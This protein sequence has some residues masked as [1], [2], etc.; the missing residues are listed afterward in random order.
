M[1]AKLGPFALA[2]ERMGTTADLT[3]PATGGNLGPAD[4]AF[5]FKPPSGIGLA[6]DAGVVKGGGYLFLDPDKGEYA[7]IL[8]LSFGPVSIKAIGI[9][10]TKLPGG[11]DG[12]ALLLLVFGE[13]SAVQLGFGFTLNGVGGIIGLQHGVSIEALQSGLRTGVLDSVLFPDDPVANAPTLI[14]QLRVVFPIVP[15]ALTVGPA[16]KLGWSTP[17]LVTLSLGIILQFDDVLGSGPGS[18]SF[19]RVVLLGQLKVQVPPVDELGIDA[20]ALIHLQVDILGAYDVP[21]QALSVDAVLRDSHVALLPITGS[22]VVRARFGDDPT[23][24]LAVGGFHPRFNDLPPGIPPQERVGLQLVY[25]IVTVRIVGYVAIT[26]N[27]FQTGA[28]ASLV[29]AGGGFRVEAY[30]GFDALFI[31]EPTFHFEIDFRVGA[32]V[33]YKS[34]S[35]ASLK[36]RGT[37][38]G[39]G[40]WEVDGHA[41][42]SLFFFDVDI[43]FEVAWGEA[44]APALPGVKVDREDRDGSV[45]PGV[46]ARRAARLRPAGDAAHRRRRQGR[47]GPPA[48]LTGRRTEGGAARHRH[49]PRRQVRAH[50]RPPLRHHRRHRRHRWRGDGRVPRRALRPGRVPRPHRGAEAVDPVLRAVPRRRLGRHR[51]LRHPRL[52]GRLRAAVGD[53]RPSPGAAD[54]DP[55]RACEVAGAPGRPRRRG[56]VGHPRRSPAH[57][58]EGPGLGGDR[59][60]HRRLR[61]RGRHGRCRLR[62]VHRG[63]PGVGEGPR[64]DVRR[65]PRRAGGEAVSY[66][67]LPHVRRGLADRIPDADGLGSTIPSRARFPV[68][69][70]LESG[71]TAGVD[72]RLYGPGDVIGV[73]PRGIVRTEP[74][75]F[76]RDVDPDGF[77]AIEFDAPDFPWMFTPARAGTNDQ[78]RPWLA[79]VVVRKQPGVSVGVGPD[80]PLPTLNIESPAVPG[81]EL[82][83]LAESWAWAHTHVVE[84]TAPASVPDHLEAHPELNLARLVCPRRLE[85]GVEYIAALVPAFESGRLAG[86]GQTVPDAATTTAAWG[87]S[88]GVGATVTLPLYFHWEFSTGPKGNFEYLARQLEPR[89]VPDTVGKR[90]MFIGA[91]HPALPSLAPDAGGVIDLEGALR[92][93]DPGTGP[94]LGP[95]HAAYVAKLTEILDAPAAYPVEG[96]SADAEAV[97]P[98]VYGA[99]HVKVETLASSTHAWLNELNSDPRHRSAAGLGTEVVRLNQERYMQSAWEQVGDVLAANALLDRAR[100]M[101]RVAD[102]I[103]NRHVRPLSPDVVLSLTASVHIRV[104]SGAHLLARDV[105]RS[106]LPTGSL[107][108]GFRRMMS[109]RSLP[110]TRAA[111]V[112]SAPGALVNVQVLPQLAKGEHKLDVLTTPP[113]GLVSSRLLS[114]FGRSPTGEV[115]AEIGAVGS[116]P[117]TLVKQLQ[118]VVR[119][120]ETAP[121]GP[122]VVLRPDLA[123][124]GVLLPRQ[125]ATIEAVVSGA[126]L[127]GTIASQGGTTTVAGLASAVLGAVRDK[128]EA[129]GFMLPVGVSGVELQLLELAR[130]EPALVARPLAGGDR[131]TTVARLQPDSAVTHDDLRAAVA[132]SR[133]GAF[134]AGT[135]GLPTIPIHG[136]GVGPPSLPG[137]GGLS[138]PITLPGGQ[139]G[140]ALPIDPNRPTLSID[141]PIKQPSVVKAFVDAFQGQRATLEITATSVIPAPQDAGPHGDQ[142][143]PRRRRRPP[144]GHRGSG[145]DGGADRGR[146]PAGRTARHP[147]PPAPA[148]R[149]D[150]GRPRDRRAAVRRAG[151]R[152]SR[153]VPPGDRRHPRRHDH[154]AGDEPPLRGGLPGRRQ[155]RDEPRAAVAA[156]P[157]RPSRHP[158]PPVLG[159][160]RQGSRH[161]SHPRVPVEPAAGQQLRR[162]PP[163]LAGPARPRPAAAALPALSR[164]RRPRAARTGSS[165]RHRRSWRTRSS[166]DGS[167]RT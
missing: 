127:T 45:R 79:L 144:P 31:F 54:A 129:I 132:R 59:R 159:P 53:V 96:A 62:H 26:S 115:G 36:V 162:R 151:R 40:R 52:G 92:A 98:P 61:H 10:T 108:A 49:R 88:G 141:P 80:R 146:R 2:V 33:R 110:L 166:G 85:S 7:G 77:A 167:R 142:D 135:H 105:A 12:W 143:D 71:Q 153:P 3:F 118:G 93:P 23:F 5:D 148:A 133:P 48:E 164:V 150:H 73:D 32:S 74:P 34:I 156:L 124:T 66:R 152:R 81:D 29:A 123:K 15:R 21:E 6:L 137:V 107:D 78:L 136:G 47:A 24:I 116:A 122:Q 100:L 154:A 42:I 158:V 16:L 30:I 18:P 76:A 65:R 75:R 72:L 11:Q 125:L 113:D 35:L 95:E 13:F 139:G 109:P 51:R 114:R 17:A 8:E 37:L 87:G 86:L 43:D 39:P 106:T 58:H 50:R 112:A 147:L 27:T 90:P 91:A 69:V 64:H 56:P 165:T 131:F 140:H 163:R 97:A 9:L 84:E 20:P 70:T 67:F 157:D 121:V 104:A 82:P 55:S 38:S 89:P 60:V 120:L 99:R 155:P 119:Q 134:D 83:N 57:R 19:T 102:R 44:A 117:A 160:R 161:R 128:P 14:G 126:G 25:G 130:F 111:R 1:G 94:S 68:T 63:P 103:L 46:L 28:E 138:G 149:P 145:P 22:L 4:L 41:S 101:Q